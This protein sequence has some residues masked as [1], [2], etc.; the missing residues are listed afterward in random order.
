MS[1]KFPRGGSRTFFSSKSICI[2]GYFLK[3]NVQNR[4]FFFFWGGGL[5]KFQIC[6]GVCLIFQIFSGVRSKPTYDEKVRVP[7]P[8]FP[9]IKAFF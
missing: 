5:L 6:L 8:P 2:L 4:D 1:A 9:V 7:P 3:A